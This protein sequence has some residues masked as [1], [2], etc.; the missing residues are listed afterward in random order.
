MPIKKSQKIA[1]QEKLLLK[2]NEQQVSQLELQAST[3]DLNASLELM[4]LHRL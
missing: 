3:D 4:V 2:Q 1:Q